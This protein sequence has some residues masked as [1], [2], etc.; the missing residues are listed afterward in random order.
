M[1]TLM[2]RDLDEALEDWMELIEALSPLSPDALDRTQLCASE[3]RETEA[4]ER[5]RRA[6]LLETASRIENASHR[7]H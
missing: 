2:D 7:R 1:R 3:V 5:K 4:S 6:G